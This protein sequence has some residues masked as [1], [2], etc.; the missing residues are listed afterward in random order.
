MPRVGFYGDDFTGSVDAL[1]QYRVAGLSGVL[2]TSP[3]AE[4]PPGDAQVVGIAGTAR[5]LA[6]SDMAAEV[7]PALSRLRELDVEVVQYKACSTADSSPEVGSLGRVLELAREVFPTSGPVPVAFAQ[8][9][10][11]RYTVFGHHFA[12][13]GETVHRLDRQPT[14][15]SHPV[16]PATESDLRLHLAAQTELPLG[17]LHWPELADPAHVSEVLGEAAEA[18]VVCDAFDDTHLDAV[19]VAFLAGSA[20]P[21]FALGA[22]G[23][24]KALGRALDVDERFGALCTDA[25]ASPGP[26]LVLSGSR[27]ALTQRQLTAAGEAG[28][29]TVD[30]FGA[31]AVRRI[32]RYLALGRE[33]AVDSTAS[34]PQAA[35]ASSA[36]EERLAEI[37]DACLRQDPTTRL[38]LCGGDTSG[39]VL[40]RLGI[41]RLSI[42]SQPWGNVVLCVAVGSTPHLR[43]VEVVL[44]GGQMGHMN[45]F[46]DVR[47]GRRHE[48]G[49]PADPSLPATP[50]P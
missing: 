45:L 32:R 7:G 39:N 31:G 37:A 1:L 36:I 6:T 3:G 12:R 30:P 35:L 11:G 48:S 14:M 8:P 42:E 10:F 21:R 19:A 23:L 4:L 25:P 29:K 16:T 9:D 5:S 44:K 18:A 26:T 24:S 50:A 27:S 34:M 28:W 47:K 22:G 41:R 49:A 2:V 40:R 15:R 20:R 46:D 33:V 43:R 13:D 17:S 38:V